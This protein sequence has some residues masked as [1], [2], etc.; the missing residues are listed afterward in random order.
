MTEDIEEF[1]LEIPKGLKFTDLDIQRD[2]ETNDITLNIDVVDRVL[3]ANDIDLDEL[4]E[5]DFLSSML[6]SWYEQ[7]LESGGERNPVLE[8]VRV[9]L[10]GDE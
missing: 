8:D 9:E 1:Q 6:V 3:E 10:E 2:T 7:W 5:D 4:D